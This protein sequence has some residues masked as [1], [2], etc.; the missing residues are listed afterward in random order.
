MKKRNRRKTSSIGNVYKRIKKHNKEYSLD[1]K[2]R[3]SSIKDFEVGEEVDLKYK[4]KTYKGKIT[5][6]N[7]KTYTVMF[8]YGKVLICK[9]NLWGILDSVK[10]DYTGDGRRFVDANVQ[11]IKP[12]DSRTK[13]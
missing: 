11:L 8:D 1:E 7:I 4:K 5:K 12:D 13:K 3:L 9:D 2:A 10:Y 6:I